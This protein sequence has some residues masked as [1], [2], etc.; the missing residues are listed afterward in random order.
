M[1]PVHTY[2]DKTCY[3]DTNKHFFNPIIAIIIIHRPHTP[4]L[5]YLLTRI[6]CHSPR[7]RRAAITGIFQCECSGKETEYHNAL[8]KDHDDDDMMMI[9][10]LVVSFIMNHEQQPKQKQQQTHKKTSKNTI[11]TTTQQKARHHTAAKSTNKTTHTVQEKSWQPA[12]F[13]RKLQME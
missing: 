8:L 2:E 7:H 5:T 6:L 9:L 12:E 13:H 4:L 3:K 10:L 1:I 11:G